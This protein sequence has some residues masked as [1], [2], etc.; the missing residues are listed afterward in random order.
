MIWPTELTALTELIYQADYLIGR[1]PEWQYQYWSDLNQLNLTK[2]P[3]RMMAW[4]NDIPVPG[5]QP[6]TGKEPEQTEWTELNQ[7]SSIMIN[8]DEEEE[9]N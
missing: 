1:I 3:S 8:G 5:S 2:D 9:P 6:Y 7:H 4:L